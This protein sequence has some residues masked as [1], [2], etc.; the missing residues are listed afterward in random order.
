MRLC[1]QYLTSLQVK[2]TGPNFHAELIPVHS[3]LLWGYVLMSFPPLTY[4]LKFS[5]FA[6]L[7]SCQNRVKERSIRGAAT[8]TA[9]G[10]AD[11]AAE[12]I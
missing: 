10:R 1:W 7:T 11:M 6:D 5:G 2:A 4:M 9:Q 3:P 12:D 8:T